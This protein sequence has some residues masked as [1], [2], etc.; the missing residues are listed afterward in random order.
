MTLICLGWCD[1]PQ[2]TFLPFRKVL[3]DQQIP[4]FFFCKAKL[5][6]IV[7]VYVSQFVI[8]SVCAYILHFLYPLI[9]K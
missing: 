6:L 3:S 9:H 8:V 7:F 4:F 5:Y 1:H 2:A